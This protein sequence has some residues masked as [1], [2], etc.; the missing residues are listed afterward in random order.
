MSGFLIFADNG[1]KFDEKE[2]AEFAR[3]LPSV[4]AIKY[5]GAP[6]ELVSFVFRFA[7]HKV[8]VELREGSEVVVL[9]AENSASFEFSIC[10]QKEAGHALRIINESYTFDSVISKFNNYCELEQAFISS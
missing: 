2:F 10:L 8:D 3:G 9:H 5:G 1:S 7:E 6:G 4:E